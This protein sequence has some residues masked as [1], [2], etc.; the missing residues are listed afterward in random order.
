MKT[1]S[2][3]FSKHTGFK[4]S[5][6]TIKAMEEYAIQFKS[7]KMPSDDEIKASIDIHMGMRDF[8]NIE[9]EKKLISAFKSL[10]YQPSK[11]ESD[12][13]TEFVLRT[14][15]KD[16]L[17]KK[18]EWFEYFVGFAGINGVTISK[19][20]NNAKV[21]NSEKEA[22]NFN[23]DNRDKLAFDFDIFKLTNK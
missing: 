22:K 8:F 6:G 11:A 17:N 21:F 3:I 16:A 5:E 7:W 2:E 23:N 20:I 4:P 9:D 1:A 18:I 13:V 15:S 10:S 12:A 14:K 19:N